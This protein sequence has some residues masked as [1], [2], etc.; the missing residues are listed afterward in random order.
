MKPRQ[1][2]W[3]SLISLTG[4]K[5]LSCKYLSLFLCTVC[6]VS[7]SLCNNFSCQYVSVPRSQ[8]QSYVTASHQ[9]GSF[10]CNRLI[11]GFF[12]I[13]QE[14]FC[15]S[16]DT[17]WYLSPQLK[18]PTQKPHAWVQGHWRTHGHTCHIC[19]QKRCIHVYINPVDSLLHLRHT[20]RVYSYKA[21]SNEHIK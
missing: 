2:S 10:F 12:F 13:S 8:R 15:Q 14:P 1:S 5:S 4:Y 7:V 3:S 18:Q 17:C 11:I 20:N 19:G 21:S 16:E 6:D 9:T